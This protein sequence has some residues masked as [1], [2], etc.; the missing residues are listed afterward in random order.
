M[1]LCLEFARPQDIP[2]LTELLG[3]LFRQEKDFRP[4]PKKQ[5]AGLRM[6]LRDTKSGRL[7]VARS[8]GKVVGMVSLLFSISTAEGG[9]V[10]W[11]EDFVV[12]PAWRGKGIGAQLLRHVIAYARKQKLKRITLLTDWNNLNAVRIYQRES[13]CPSKMIPLRL[14]M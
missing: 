11:L 5:S 3:E 8:G 1:K 9:P 14:K 2:R 13:F 4:D 7:F 10:A 6:I 12:D